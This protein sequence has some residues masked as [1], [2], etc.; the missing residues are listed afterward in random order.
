MAKNKNAKQVKSQ[1][2][3]H[4]RINFLY[5]AIKHFA[6]KTDEGSQSI[7]KYYARTLKEVQKKSLAKVHPNIKRTI[8]RKCR[9]YLSP[10]SNSVK[11]RWKSKNG[12]RQQLTVSCNECG[13]V[14]RFVVSSKDEIKK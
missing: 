8:C 6:E 12:S 9:Q 2:P 10:G 11:I 14:K 3:Y 1:N 13:R 7:S 4:H 5:Q